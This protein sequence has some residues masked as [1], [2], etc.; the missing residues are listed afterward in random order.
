MSDSGN[1]LDSKR[2]AQFLNRRR[3]VQTAGAAGIAALAGCDG[4]GDGNDGNADGG[5]DGGSDDD[6]TDDGTTTDG[7]SGG[8]SGDDV[9]YWTLFGGGDGETM[10]SMVES[11]NA[12]TDLT[13]N[14]QRVP[15]GEYYDRLY[16]SLTGG[17]APDVA[18]MHADRL[19]EYQDLVV[20]LTDQISTDPYAESILDRVTV[21]DEL[22]GVPL[23]THPQGL[24]YNKDI[25]EEAGLDPESPPQTPEEFQSANEAI[26]ENTDHN[27]GQIH[28]GGLS[29]G[30]FHM[31]LRS[32]G[33]Q[34]LNDDRSEAAFD[35]EDG[36]AV[37]DFYDTMVNENG[38]IPQSSDEGWNAWNNGEAGWLL[39]GTW[40]LSVVRDLDFDFGLA[41]PY[42]M[43]GSDDPVTSGNSHTLVVPR[44]ESRSD[45]TLQQAVELIRLLTQDYNLQWGSDAGH[46]PAS[47]SALESDELRDTDTW[48]QSL[49]TFYEMATN[50]KVA[51][52]PRTENNGEWTPEIWQRLNAVRQDDTEP[53][54]AIEKAAQGVN[55]VL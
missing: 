1:N 47:Q 55:Q 30:F 13:V 21:E 41:K 49:S 37:A 20:P 11:V 44:S 23:D 15:F 28:A 6:G 33:A 48:D 2:T 29:M 46:L 18:V 43:P 53:E 9:T 40:H 4:S 50:G 51:Y 8:G 7:N 16:T 38:W 34:V 31:S 36:I 22:L 5:S 14:R 17:E 10:Q 32:R 45:E 54:E 24:W 3:F 26:A 12:D 35:N 25:F 42:M 19:V 39:D 52:M 27:V